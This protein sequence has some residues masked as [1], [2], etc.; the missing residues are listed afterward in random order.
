[1]TRTTK[2]WW[3]EGEGMTLMH[4]GEPTASGPTTDDMIV[5]DLY[6]QYRA[7]LMSFVL[8]LTA[9]D[10]QQAEDVVQ[11]T[12]VRAWRQGGQLDVTP[13][14]V[15]PWLAPGGRRVAR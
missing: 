15:T 1:M 4:M 12:M 9:G 5:S 3:I 11:E 8:R 14:A 10:R 7:P 13:P 6:R 2:R